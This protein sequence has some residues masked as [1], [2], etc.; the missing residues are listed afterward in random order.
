MSR[1]CLFSQLQIFIYTFIRHSS[2]QTRVA[3]LV[4]GIIISRCYAT[5][6]VTVRFLGVS[7]DGENKHNW[8]NARRGVRAKL[9]TLVYL[10]TL[11]TKEA[12]LLYSQQHDF[13]FCPGD[14]GITVSPNQGLYIK[15]FFFSPLSDVQSVRFVLLVCNISSSEPSG[16]TPVLHVPSCVTLWHETL[17][18]DNKLVSNSIFFLS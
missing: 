2:L 5:V 13:N 8:T 15:S 1:V 14:E 11:A 6:I 12:T 7:G 3:R 4:L 16:L 18:P 9:T 10:F 17:S